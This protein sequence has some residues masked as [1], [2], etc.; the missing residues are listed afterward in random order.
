MSILPPLAPLAAPGRVGSI[1]P[2]A[3]RSAE[4][5]RALGAADKLGLRLAK[6]LVQRPLMSVWEGTRKEDNARLT[7]TV[8]DA[9]ATDAERTRILA[10]AKALRDSESPGVQRVRQVGAEVD[11]F[12]S[13]HFA[14]GTAADLLLLRWP[15]LER[16]NFVGRVCDALEA[17]HAAGHVHASLCPENILLDDD[18]APILSEV[19]MV[20]LAES[21][22][23]DRE[24]FFGYGAYAAPETQTGRGIDARSDVFS[25]GRL[26]AYLVLER[27]PDDKCAEDLVKKGAPLAAVFRKATA[28]SPLQRHESAAELRADLERIRGD[29]SA[30]TGTAKARAPA[31]VQTNASAQRQ[32]VAPPTLRHELTRPRPLYAVVGMLAAAAAL[33]ICMLAPVSDTVIALMSIATAV[34]A[35]VA[36]LAIPVSAARWRLAI[37]LAM[38]GIVVMAGPARVAAMAGARGRLHGATPA[39]REAIVKMLRNGERQLGGANLAGADLSHLDLAWV[40]LVGANLADVDFTGANLTAARLD[41]AA[42]A[43][44]ILDGADLTDTDLGAAQGA[45][46]ARC[47]ATTMPPR[48]WRCDRARLVWIEP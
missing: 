4:H 36:T 14:S 13:D 17:L 32:R 8:V 39:G 31:P 37:A 23:G 11:A 35:G 46:G 22:E 10:G 29:V 18:F 30:A 38:A 27:E 12:V 28:P 34:A 42:L 21:L 24:G 26:L 3:R 41:R 1:P 6:K 40:D 19:G 7:L 2:S 33:G 47:S 20:S 44:A 45:E 16:L 25:A 43:G 15:L 48:G 9:C 5:G